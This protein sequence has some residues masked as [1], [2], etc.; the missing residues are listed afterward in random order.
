MSLHLVKGIQGL[1]RINLILTKDPGFFIDINEVSEGNSGE[2][3][4]RHKKLLPA[5]GV[6]DNSLCLV[7]E[8]EGVN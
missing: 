5:L 3:T 1:V 6:T 7:L 2:I 8:L 4:E